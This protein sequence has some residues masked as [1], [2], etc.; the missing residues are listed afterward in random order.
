MNQKSRFFPTL[1]L[2]ALTLS[3]LACG[4]F[5]TPPATE[6]SATEP[7]PV[8]APVDSGSDPNVVVP[9]SQLVPADELNN[10]LFNA[11][12]TLVE[13]AYPGGTSCEWQ[14]TPN[15]GS[16]ASLFYIQTSNDPALW[17]ATRKSELSNEPSDIVVNSIDGLADES[18]VWSSKVTGLYVVY[19]RKGDKTLILRF[20]PQDVLYMANE[21]GIIDMTDRF[22]SRF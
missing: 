5:S 6:A 1:G 22:F 18:Y 14:Y 17:E 13:N 4:A 7:P 15:G 21:S 20:A 16:Q 8:S 2:V 12:A 11:P 9:C 3:L 10:L 19:A